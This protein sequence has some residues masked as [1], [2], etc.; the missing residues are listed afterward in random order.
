M[1]WKAGFEHS[2]LEAIF[3]FHLLRPAKKFPH[4]VHRSLIARE[5]EKEAT[6]QEKNS[7]VWHISILAVYY[8]VS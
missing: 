6:E 1:R 4:T 2:S 7:D 8:L 5:R 3:K